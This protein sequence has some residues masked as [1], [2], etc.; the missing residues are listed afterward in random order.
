[1]YH[2]IWSINY[3]TYR[4]VSS[5]LLIFRCNS[6]NHDG[7]AVYVHK[8]LYFC[9]A[10][11]DIF[12]SITINT[13][14]CSQKFDSWWWPFYWP[15][16]IS[17]SP[18]RPRFPGNLWIFAGNGIDST[19]RILQKWSEVL[20]SCMVCIQI[21]WIA[22]VYTFCKRSLLLNIIV[23]D[24]YRVIVFNARTR[25]YRLVPSLWKWSIFH[26]EVCHRFYII[27]AVKQH[28]IKGCFSMNNR[29]YQ[30]SRLKDYFG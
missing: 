7:G 10:F 14:S 20:I 13:F 2:E 22:T 28:G 23:N 19:S 8:R 25:I 18:T 12:I 30:M 16:K 5:V 1:M 21:L 11:W 27:I 3:V 6:W 29:D 24:L 17:W 4:R 26:S 9:I 15:W